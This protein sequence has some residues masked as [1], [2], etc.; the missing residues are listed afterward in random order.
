MALTLS[1]YIATTCDVRQL[2][3]AFR[4]ELSKRSADVATYCVK[5]CPFFDGAVEWDFAQ[6]AG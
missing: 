3:H 4:A 5:F 6:D 1:V 2:E